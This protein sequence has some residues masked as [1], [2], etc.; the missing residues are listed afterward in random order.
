M[1]QDAKAKEF[2]STPGK[3]SVY[4]YRNETLGA[5]IPMT[6]TIAGKALR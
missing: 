4:I 5:A 1:D 3:A 2:L 6:V